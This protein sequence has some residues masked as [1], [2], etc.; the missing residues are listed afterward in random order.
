MAIKDIAKFGALG[1][2]AA[3]AAK[4]P[5]FLRSLGLV[6]GYAANKLED[7]EEKKRREAE[8]AAAGAAPAPGTP[9]VPAGMKKGGKVSSAS[10]R[11]DGCA[12]RGKT[13]A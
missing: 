2:G 13:R 6:G 7:R 10:K 8:M 11:A 5:D 1:A 4:N 12:I 9:V 3:L